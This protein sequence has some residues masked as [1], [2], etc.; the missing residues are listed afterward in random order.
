MIASPFCPA[1]RR[2]YLSHRIYS[3]RTPQI[4]AADVGDAVCASA[5]AAA[6]TIFFSPV[7]TSRPTTGSAHA[8]SHFVETDDYTAISGL[9]LFSGCDPANPLIAREWR[10]ACPYVGDNWVGFDCFAKILRHLVDSTGGGHLTKPV[11]HPGIFAF[12]TAGVCTVQRR[13]PQTG[14]VW[15]VGA[16]RELALNICAASKPFGARIVTFLQDEDGF[17]PFNPCRRT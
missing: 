9:V 2:L 4:P 12:Q 3:V 16:T 17:G 8:F 13:N 14:Q 5:N 6:A 11:A 10:N 1:R 7:R 15:M